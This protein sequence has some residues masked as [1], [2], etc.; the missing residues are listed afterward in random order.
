MHKVPL[1]ALPHQQ[2]LLKGLN[3][4]PVSLIKGELKIG[5]SISIGFVKTVVQQKSLRELPDI[6][7]FN[8]YETFIKTS[9]LNGILF[10]CN[11]SEKS[12]AFS[13]VLSNSYVLAISAD[14]KALVF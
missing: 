10:A 5:T 14:S 3:R 7:P 11:L 4:P 8:V 13:H 9:L 6:I 1:V 12:N 2:T